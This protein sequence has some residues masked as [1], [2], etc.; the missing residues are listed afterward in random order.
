M[1]S[2]S[3][4]SFAQSYKENYEANG[5]LK[6]GD[7]ITVEYELDADDECEI[8]MYL[9]VS[10]RGG[11][12]AFQPPQLLSLYLFFFFPSA[13]YNAKYASPLSNHLAA[14]VDVCLSIV[15]PIHA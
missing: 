15:Q 8:T 2:N 6:H 12:K 14:R 3:C 10:E 1:D 13:Q 11:A 9:G 7:I 4:F 5:E